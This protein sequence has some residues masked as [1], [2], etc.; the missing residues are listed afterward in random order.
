MVSKTEVQTVHVA[1]GKLKNGPGVRR[2]ATANER[3]ML[4]E[5]L[6]KFG[7]QTAIV[8]ERD[9]MTIV[10]GHRRV[11]AAKELNWLTVGVQYVTLTKEEHI[12][13]MLDQ[14]DPRK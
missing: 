3:K 12:R 11:A 9:S 14:S 10:D 2:P 4:I 5:S 7:Q 8:V 6:F 13:W 1:I